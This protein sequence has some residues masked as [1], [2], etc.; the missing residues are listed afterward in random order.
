MPKLHKSDG[1]YELDKKTG[2]LIVPGEGET[3][4]ISS[5][6]K[7]A[8]D[9]LSALYSLSDTLRHGRYDHV[10]T[11]V[12]LHIVTDSDLN[13][14]RGTDLGVVGVNLED[15]S[16]G[17]PIPYEQDYKNGWAQINIR[18]YRYYLSHFGKAEIVRT[19]KHDFVDAILQGYGFEIGI[20][21]I[22]ANKDEH[23]L[24]VVDY[25]L[26]SWEEDDDAVAAQ[27]RLD[28]IQRGQAKRQLRRAWAVGKRR[29]LG[30]TSN[31][32]ES[33]ED[34]EEPQGK[35]GKKNGAIW[36]TSYVNPEEKFDL[37]Q[38][39]HQSVKIYENPRRP[40]SL[41]WDGSDMA[42]L[43]FRAVE[44]RGWPCQPHTS[45]I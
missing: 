25:V 30:V 2:K 20:A 8:D 41:S 12:G 18:N 36:L 33:E 28:G 24:G 22:N 29:G 34:D 40:M 7:D 19:R 31:D 35:N 26:A 32:D 5:Q 45:K 43:Q 4:V 23:G 1:W 15:D 37:S 3:I 16:L 21:C 44:R 6:G 38:L 10:L 42:V 14:W 39:P 11:Q 27:I 13:G 9:A 17:I